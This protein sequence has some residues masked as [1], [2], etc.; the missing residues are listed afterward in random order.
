MAK[1]MC[2]TLEGASPYVLQYVHPCSL[3]SSNYICLTV[4]GTWL[5][6][7]VNT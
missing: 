4:G 7:A 6:T 3:K 2:E 5:E 1:L